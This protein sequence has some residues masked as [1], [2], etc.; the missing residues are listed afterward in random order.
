MYNSTINKIYA[1]DYFQRENRT[2]H[3]INLSCHEI[4]IS[5]ILHIVIIMIEIIIYI[6]LL[7]SNKFTKDVNNINFKHN[8]WARYTFFYF[9]RRFF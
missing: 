7:K 1:Q 2:D 4:L 6:I 5:H 8:C 9:C 3:N